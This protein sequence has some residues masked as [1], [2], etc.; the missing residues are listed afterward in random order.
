MLHVRHGSRK[1]TCVLRSDLLRSVLVQVTGLPAD[2][3]K[4]VLAVHGHDWVRAAPS[5][6]LAPPA[7]LPS[8]SDSPDSSPP[9]PLS[10]AGEWRPD[11]PHGRAAHLPQPGPA[12]R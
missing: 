12:S 6:S 8:R 9:T 10:G 2:D 7:L 11:Q 3:E 5:G 1:R 4:I